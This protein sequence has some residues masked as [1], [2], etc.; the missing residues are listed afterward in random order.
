MAINNNDIEKSKSLSSK[1]DG[2]KDIY[3]SYNS[4]SQRG[5]EKSVSK[6]MSEYIR[7]GFAKF[8][9]KKT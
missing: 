6:A 8:T 2:K 9:T 7:V 1:S 5:K 4:L 3:I